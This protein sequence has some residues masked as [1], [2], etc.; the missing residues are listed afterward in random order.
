MKATFNGDDP[1]ADAISRAEAFLCRLR[2]RV[3]GGGLNQV[4]AGVQ[5]KLAGYRELAGK[6]RDLQGPTPDLNAGQP[7]SGGQEVRQETR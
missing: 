1:Q 7:Y 2:S 6:M 4:S 3:Y 5:G